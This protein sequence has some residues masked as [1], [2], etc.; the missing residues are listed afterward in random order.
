M[1][2]VHVIGWKE[3]RSVPPLSFLEA[4]VSRNSIEQIAQ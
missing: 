4:V 1:I 3:T 2:F